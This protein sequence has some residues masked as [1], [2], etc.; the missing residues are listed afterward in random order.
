MNQTEFQSE[1]NDIEIVIL[2]SLML[3][4]YYSPKINNLSLLKQSMSNKDFVLTSQ[5]NHLTGLMQ[6]RSDKKAEINKMIIDYT[7]MNGDIGALR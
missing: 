3:I 4:E 2:G 6:L 5:A 7:Y 1:L